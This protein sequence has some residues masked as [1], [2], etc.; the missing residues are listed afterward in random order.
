[1]LLNS[2]DLPLKYHAVFHASKTPGVLQQT[3]EEP[4]EKDDKGTCELNKHGM[5]DGNA[6]FM[7]KKASLS[8]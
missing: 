4:S 3:F 2:F 7:I 1:M 6:R 8:L 5:L